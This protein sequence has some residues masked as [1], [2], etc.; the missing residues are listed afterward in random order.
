[1]AIKGFIIFLA[2]TLCGCLATIE[3]NYMSQMEEGTLFQYWKQDMDYIVNFLKSPSLP[4]YERIDS[5]LVR[6]NIH[7]LRFKKLDLKTDNVKLVIDPS[8]LHINFTQDVGF[9]FE[10]ELFWEYNLLYLPISGTA[11]FK[12]KGRNVVYTLNLTQPYDGKLLIPTLECKWDIMSSS[13]DSPLGSLFGIPALIEKTFKEAMYGPIMD[14]LDEN[15]RDDIPLRYE[16]YYSPKPDTISFP[17]LGNAQV[18]VMRRYKRVY[19]DVHLLAFVYQEIV[20]HVGND[21]FKLEVVRG[22]QARNDGYAGSGMLR[23]YLRDFAVFEQIAKKLLS[24]IHHFT[25][26]EDDLPKDQKMRL[27]SDAMETL[28][29][30]FKDKY[31]KNANITLHITGTNEF[32]SPVMTPMNPRLVRLSDVGF[33]MDFYVKD[34]NGVDVCFLQ[35]AL[36]YE[37]ELKPFNMWKDGRMAIN[38]E[39]MSAKNELLMAQSA[40]FKKIVKEA[41]KHFTELG[42]WEFLS[43]KCKTEMLGDGLKLRDELG[44]V[45]NAVAVLDVAGRTINT[46]IYLA[47]SQQQQRLMLNAFIII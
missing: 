13:V 22:T 8:Q 11:V 39:I 10:V 27:N 6:C 23:R 25:I 21:D 30:S 32:S 47:Q 41:V 36:K 37:F 17:G 34:E 3:K 40:V 45:E 4:T 2:F 28:V 43:K 9:D 12:G 16:E 44:T 19:I 20:D 18:D 38:F 46:W 31:G 7:G 14:A 29:P 15:M 1:M 26:T 35:T 24:Q 42:T 33:K 5:A